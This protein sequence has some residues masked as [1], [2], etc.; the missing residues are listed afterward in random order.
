MDA[1]KAVNSCVQIS[2]VR[3]SDDFSAGGFFPIPSHLR[4]INKKRAFRLIADM[5]GNQMSI[6]DNSPDRQQLP[7][8]PAFRASL[9]RTAIIPAAYK[10]QEKKRR[11]RASLWKWLSFAQGLL[12]EHNVTS[13][14]SGKPHKTRLCY[15]RIAAGQQKVV[16]KLNR[17]PLKSRANLTNLQTCLCIWACP[18]CAPRRALEKAKEIREALLFAE[19]SELLPVMV[20]L[21]ARHNAGMRLADF[22]T[23]FKAAWAFYSNHRQW[24]NAKTA[25]GFKH[26]IVNREITHGVNGWHYH[27]H[28]LLFVDKAA[29]AKLDDTKAMQDALA[30][31]WMHCLAKVGLDALEKRALVLSADKNIGEFYLTKLGGSQNVQQGDLAFELTGAGKKD[32][33]TVWDILRHAYYGDEVSAHLYTEYVQAMTGDNWITWSKGLHDLVNDF[34]DENPCSDEPQGEAMANWLNISKYW[35]ELVKIVRGHHIIVE[36]SAR[37]RDIK[38]VRAA[39]HNIRGELAEAD[40]LPVYHSENL[41]KTNS[42]ADVW[43]HKD[44]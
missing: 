20:T 15:T 24:K 12:I 36:V 25:F 31:H 13:K 41:P 37:T 11:K 26:K 2:C 38:E 8:K 39:L 35:W 10:K 29:L 42:I 19:Y 21:T 1:E 3:Y 18:I 4:G 33:R 28:L 27:M 32:S 44:W 7:P 14:R 40:S 30:E 23:D 22:K 16:V 5:S 43:T 17:N 34:M 9:G 6:P